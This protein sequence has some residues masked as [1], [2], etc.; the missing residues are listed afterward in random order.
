M[1]IAETFVGCYSLNQDQ[2]R[3]NF[4]PDLSMYHLVGFLKELFEKSQQ[5]TR[6]HMKN[7][8]AFKELMVCQFVT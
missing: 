2:K 7:Y 6:K 1:L 4:G 5:T 3:K 8:A